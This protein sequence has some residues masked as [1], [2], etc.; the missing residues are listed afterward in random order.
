MASGHEHDRTTRL[1]SV[2]FGL[3][4]WLFLDLSSGLISALAF[5]IGG[6]WLSPDLDTKSNALYRWGWLRG[7]W[8]PYRKLIR[9]RSFLSHGPLIGTTIRVLYLITTATIILLS[10]KALGISQPWHGFQE[11]IKLLDENRRPGIAVILGLEASAWLHLIQDGDPLP[12]ESRE[13]RHHE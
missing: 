6:Q 8:W 1:L 11:C 3:L 7:I 13:K 10:L 5:S 2:P 9:H 12:S 4:I